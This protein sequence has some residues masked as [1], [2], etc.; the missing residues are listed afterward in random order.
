V[1]QLISNDLVNLFFAIAN[2]IPKLY[3]YILFSS[4]RDHISSLLLAQSYLLNWYLVHVLDRI[5]NRITEYKLVV[6]KIQLVD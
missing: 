5:N 4:T 3:G 1:T 6:M 2:D